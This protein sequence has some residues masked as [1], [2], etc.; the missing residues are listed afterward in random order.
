MP[1]SYQG[2]EQLMA[3]DKRNRKLPK[4]IRQKGNRFEGRV[5][6]QEKTHSVY[7]NT[8]KETQTKMT[9]LRY[10]L[11]HGIFVEKNKLTFEQW[12]NTWLD[13]YKKIRSKLELIPV[14]KNTTIV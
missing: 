9:E 14:T 12:Y 6:Y 5:T 13:E 1:K 3:V 8:V 2:K 10:K 11:E 4:G 7:G